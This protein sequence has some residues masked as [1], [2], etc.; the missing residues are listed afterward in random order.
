MYLSVLDLNLKNSNAKK[1][2]ELIRNPLF[3]K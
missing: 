2:K 1:I 3:S